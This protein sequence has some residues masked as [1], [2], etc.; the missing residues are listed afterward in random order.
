MTDADKE[1]DAEFKRL[2]RQAAEGD[3][4]FILVYV[5]AFW[6]AVAVLGYGIWR[7]L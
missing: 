1:R 5:I 3:D 7:L 6:L 4:R 2:V